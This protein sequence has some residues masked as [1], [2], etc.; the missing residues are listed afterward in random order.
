MEYTTINICYKD[1]FILFV[2]YEGHLLTSL[3]ETC[4]SRFFGRKRIIYSHQDSLDKFFV[5]AKSQITVQWMLVLAVFAANQVF[6]LR[7]YPFH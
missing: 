1:V 4:K 6:A 3:N 5:V 2:S 7:K